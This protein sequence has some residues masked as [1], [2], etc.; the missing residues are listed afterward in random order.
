MFEVCSYTSVGWQF[1]NRSFYSV[2]RAL[3]Y[4]Y[5]DLGNYN[6]LRHEEVYKN[7]DYVIFEWSLSAKVDFC[8]PCAKHFI[9]GVHL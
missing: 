7:F 8:I 9:V 3:L 2:L 1:F 6:F 5:V 4:I